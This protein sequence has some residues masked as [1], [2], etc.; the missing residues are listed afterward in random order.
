MC[1]F[2]ISLA[3]LAVSQYSPGAANSK[4]FVFVGEKI[5]VT[6]V[7][8]K[9]GKVPFDQQ[10]LARYRVL[11]PYRGIYDGNEID[12][13]VYDH[14]GSVSFSKYN[15]VLLYVELYSGKYIHAKYQYS[16]LYRTKNGLW[17]APYDMYDY[18]HEYNKNTAIKPEI[19]DFV[20]PVEV[21]ISGLK[22]KDAGHMFPKPYYRISGRKAIAIYGNYVPELFLL[23]Q[24]GVLKARG[25]FQ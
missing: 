13:T 16:P 10:F 11:K 6:A 3:L 15:H 8:P 19:I 22:K 14:M 12:F 9:V 20:E 17:A 18:G 7:P 24:N 5:S 23:K 2:L 1:H 4:Y 25:D 21:D